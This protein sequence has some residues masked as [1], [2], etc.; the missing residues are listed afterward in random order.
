MRIKRWAVQEMEE[1]RRLYPGTPAENLVTLFRVSAVNI[2]AKASSMGLKRE[3]DR[4]RNCLYCGAKYRKRQKYGRN[5]GNSYCSHQCHIV[6][7][8]RL[9]AANAGNPDRANGM[10]YRTRKSFVAFPNCRVCGKLFTARHA[11]ISTCPLCW[12]A[13]IMERIRKAEIRGIESLSDGYVRKLCAVAMGV[14]ASL[15]PADLVDAKKLHL[16]LNRLIKEKTP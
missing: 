3:F 2:R 10:G 9:A 14:K 4:W 12:R 15:V 6:G 8:K 5:V 16:K 13:E 7:S 1:L 11:K